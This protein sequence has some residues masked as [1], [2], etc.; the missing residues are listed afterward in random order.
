MASGESARIVIA[1][2][3]IIGLG[4]A[5]HLAKAGVGDVLLV[6]RNQ[7]TSGT[8]WHA[9]GIVGTL[10]PSLNLTKLSLYATELFP[11]IE[12]ET[13]QSTGFRRTGGL[14][15]ASNEDRLTEIRRI[16][17]MG[18]LVDVHAR[19]L[20]PEEL[21]EKIPFMRTDDL[22]GALWVE[23]DGQASPV[24]ICMAYARGARDGGVRIREQTG[25]QAVETANGAVTGITLSTGEQVRCAAFVNC[26]GAWAPLLD[27]GGFVPVPVQP[28]EH[29]YVVTEPIAGLPQPFPV[30]RD[31]DNRIYI[32]EDAGKLVIGGF[33]TNAKI[34]DPAGADGD[35]PFLEFPEDWEQFEPFMEAGLNRVPALEHSGIT[36]FMNGPESFT[37]DTRQAMGESPFLKGYFVAAG[38]NSIG[39]MSSAGVGKAMAEWIIGGEPPMDLWE[40]DVARFDPEC[41]TKT[42]MA[43][44]VQEAVAAQ[45]DLHWPYKQ[46][47]TGRDLRR[48]PLHDAFAADGGVFGVTASWERPF[49]FAEDPSER[50]FAYSFQD[51]AWWPAAR[52]EAQAVRDRAALIELSPFTKIDVSGAQAL[53]LLQYLC[54]NDIDMDMGRTVYTQMLNRSG[55][56]EADVTVTRCGENDFRIVS[57]AATRWKDMAWIARAQAELG[58]S[59]AVLDVSD[60]EAVLGVMGPNAPALLND[61]AGGDVGAAFP[62]GSS[63]EI[64]IADISVRATRVSFVGE[65]GLELYVPAQ[66]AAAVYAALRGAGAALCGHFALE[67][68]RLE[69]GYRHWGHDIGADD[70]PLEAGLGFAVAWDKPSG[71]LGRDA[72]MRQR[73]AGV[74]RR[75]VL[76]AVEDGHP[77]LVHDEPIYRDGAPVGLTT[78]GTNGFRTGLSLCFGY[79]PVEPGAPREAAYE[80]RYEVGVAG[81]RF[82]LKP[83]PRPPWDPDGARMK[84]W[85]P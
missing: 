25:V 9:A 40:V 67:A 74:M 58:T 57:A 26:C 6:E 14:W 47:K 80:G 37:P 2:G 77:L 24:D 54:A 62:F 43:S 8:S 76:F 75:L 41:S 12:T 79:V 19:V 13:G 36:H 46:M 52:R 63:R 4:I 78:S 20:T 53:A 56:I 81:E 38:F 22:A 51:Q 5:Y 66:A 23:E 73:E 33:E 15:L 3:G 30:T 35:R 32:K 7:L 82:G 1:G 49:W 69:K 71:F 65:A 39:M 44:R 34:W 10:R 42:F 64:G 48:S 50:G 21:A 45:Y 85:S 68:C 17:A 61:L 27:T 83:L 29:M 16:A 84:E 72:L 31:L 59:A 60:D 55:G 70:T 28:V 18:D 11:R